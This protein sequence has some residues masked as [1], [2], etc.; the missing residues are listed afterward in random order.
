M[1]P[2]TKGLH[3][4][5]WSEVKKQCQHQTPKNK[6]TNQNMHKTVITKCSKRN[7]NM[8]KKYIFKEKLFTTEV[9]G[10]LKGAWLDYSGNTRI[11]FAA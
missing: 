8:Y 2:Q 4:K 3:G 11:T 7:K 10:I 1:R 5:Q 6:N 9:Q